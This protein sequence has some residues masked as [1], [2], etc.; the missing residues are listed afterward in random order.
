MNPKFKKPLL[1][2]VALIIINVLASFAYKRFDLTQDNRFT[3]SE[4]SH[5]IV[6]NIVAPI[7]VDVY[8]DGDLPSDF[9]RLQTETKQIL[10]EFKAMNSNVVYRF[11]NTAEN[12]ETS[13]TLVKELYKKGLAP[14]NITVS[15]KGKQ[16]QLMIFPWATINFKGKEVNVPLLKNIMGAKTEDKV[17]GSVQNL[18]YAFADGFKKATSSQKKKIA[19]IKGNGETPDPLIAKFLLQTRESYH[20][21]PFTLDSA[22]TDPISNLKSLQNYDLAIVIKPT[23]RFSETEKQVLD[24]FVINGGKAIFFIEK[25]NIDLEQLY[26]PTGEALAFPNDLNLDDLFFKYGCRIQPAI[27]KDDLGTPIKLASGAAGSETQF[28]EFNWKYAPFIV[29]ESYHPIV[30]NLGGLK[31]DFA[32]PIDTLKNNISKT[33]LLRS[34]AKSRAI[35]APCVVSLASVDEPE[36][37]TPIEA[38]ANLPVALLLEG[39]FKSVFDSR[40][41]AFKDQNF[42][43]QAKESKIIVVSDGNVV[44]N[45]IDKNGIPVEL[46]YDAKTGNLF[47]NKDF[48]QNAV[49]YM[50][51][52]SGLIFLRSKDF[53]LPLLDKEKVTR[54]YAKSQS[55]AI[56]LP[57]LLLLVFGVMFTIVRKRKYAK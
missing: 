32:N 34:S 9:K 47:D 57:L 42:K 10:E 39:K 4:V 35:G 31:F 19:I 40:I 24:Q 27:I 49:N 2:F 54:E 17:L 28:Q 14:V 52:D 46:G 15:E 13:F 3:L 56:V 22:A 38:K 1:F 8:L 20:I 44:Q 11:V 25:V 29:P 45:T 50:M 26:N 55:I 12:K 23:E 18:E 33:I 51:D 48:A 30:K 16:S 21:A 37:E 43:T 7:Y 53:S 36:S 6:D 5:K 41:L